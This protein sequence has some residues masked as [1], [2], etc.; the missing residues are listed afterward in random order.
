[1]FII[2]G[3]LLTP[4]TDYEPPYGRVNIDTDDQSHIATTAYVKGA[5]NSAIAGMNHMAE[6]KQNILYSY[7]SGAMK[8][9]Q[10]ALRGKIHMI[11]NNLC[12]TRSVFV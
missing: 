1:M 10:R 6:N 12:I 5:Y 9:P 11:F 3:F 8:M 7:W 4:S 2:L